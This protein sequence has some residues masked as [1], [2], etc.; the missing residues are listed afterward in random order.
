MLFVEMNDLESLLRRVRMA[1]RFTE[2][3]EKVS[4]EGN[5][6]FPQYWTSMLV[7]CRQVV[8]E[9]K[10][11]MDAG[12]ADVEEAVLGNAKTKRLMDSGVWREG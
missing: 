12:E 9:A 3:V 2:V 10:K 1:R 11:W 4:V 6:E 5:G 8:E 7:Q